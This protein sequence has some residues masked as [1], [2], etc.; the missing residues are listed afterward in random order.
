[1]P[2][3]TFAWC[4]NCSQPITEFG[5]GW[6]TSAEEAKREAFKVYYPKFVVH[7][8]ERAD[9]HRCEAMAAPVSLARST[10]YTPEEAKDFQQEG[11]ATDNDVE[12]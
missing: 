1:M 4:H 9:E 3:L 8:G 10:V 6:F 7:G 5:L 12:K 11:S 2:F